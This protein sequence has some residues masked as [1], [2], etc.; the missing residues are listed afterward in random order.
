MSA[1]LVAVVDTNVF[2]SG[3]L[4]PLGPPRKVLERFRNGSFTLAISPVLLGELVEVA[5]RPMLRR[6]IPLHALQELI[7]GVRDHARV[8]HP[9]TVLHGV[10]VDPDDDQ[11]FACALA[12]GASV[13]VSGDPDVLAVGAAIS[14]VETLAPAAFLARLVHH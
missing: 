12:A 7:D 8:I 4:S 13:I 10:T 9:R 11:L 6:Q 14:G 1:E 2:I 5:T 3:L